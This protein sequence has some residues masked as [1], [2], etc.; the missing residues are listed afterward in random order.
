[1]RGGL[2]GPGSWVGARAPRRGVRSCHACVCVCG[3]AFCFL[4]ML[5]FEHGTRRKGY[6]ERGRSGPIW[7]PSM[8]CSTRLSTSMR[9]PPLAAPRSTARHGVEARARWRARHFRQRVYGAERR[10]TH[11]VSPAPWSRQPPGRTRVSSIE[12]K[13]TGA[14]GHVWPRISAGSKQAPSHVGRLH[15]KKERHHTVCTQ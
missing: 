1:M 10:W 5:H 15:E 14:Q 11:E 12:L 9:I 6:M 3:S 8:S 2:G 4:A 13:A 7:V